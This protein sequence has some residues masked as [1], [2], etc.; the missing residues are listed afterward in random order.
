MVTWPSNLGVYMWQYTSQDKG[1]EGCCTF[2]TKEKEKERNQVTRVF[3]GD[4]LT[5]DII[6]FFWATFPK[7]QPQASHQDLV[8]VHVR[9]ISGP[10]CNL[11]PLLIPGL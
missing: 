4:N 3:F 1:G 10:D 11:P 7:A 8:H 9:N 6:S 5:D 2:A